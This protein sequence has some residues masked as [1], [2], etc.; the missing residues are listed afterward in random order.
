MNPKLKDLG[1]G[2]EWWTSFTTVAT[3]DSDVVGCIKRKQ[4]T[5]IVGNSR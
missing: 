2:M 5:N 3:G 4:Q 1:T